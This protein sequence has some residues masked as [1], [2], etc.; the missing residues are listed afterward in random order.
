MP[1]GHQQEVFKEENILGVQPYKMVTGTW[2]L[3]KMDFLVKQ[4]SHS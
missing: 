4:F 1:L 2:K 3:K